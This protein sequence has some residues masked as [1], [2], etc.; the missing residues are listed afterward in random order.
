MPNPKDYDGQFF[1]KE[2]QES[3]QLYFGGTED[4][5]EQLSR[6]EQ[7]LDRLLSILDKDRGLWVAPGPDEPFG[8]YNKKAG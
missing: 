5:N 3:L 6:I 4:F 7:K 1:H 8:H 2:Y